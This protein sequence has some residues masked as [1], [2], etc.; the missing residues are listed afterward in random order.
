MTI[1]I[2][3]N[4]KSKKGRATLEAGWNEDRKRYEESLRNPQLEQFVD[5][6]VI[7]H[8]WPENKLLLKEQGQTI[9]QAFKQLHKNSHPLL[10]AAI[11]IYGEN[12]VSANT[13]IAGFK[14]A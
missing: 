1:F 14:D 13:V 9:A 12:T 8:E 6:S 11:D 2:A 7:V 3:L 5:F 4:E 10:Q